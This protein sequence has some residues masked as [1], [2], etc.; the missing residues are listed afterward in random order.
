MVWFLR[1]VS[2][3]LGQLFFLEEGILFGM[4]QPF[5]FIPRSDIKKIHF[6]D[7]T[8]RTF[9]MTVSLKNGTQQTFSMIAEADMSSIAFYVKR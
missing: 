3:R 7:V 4:K 6:E 1:F 5:I 2:H 9:S 8:T